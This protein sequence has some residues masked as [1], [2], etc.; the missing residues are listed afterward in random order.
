MRGTT[1]PHLIVRKH[2][3]CVLD[4][5]RLGEA[6]GQQV[7]PLL[8]TI[9]ESDPDSEVRRLAGLSLAGWNTH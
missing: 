8:R 7:I 6:V 5:R 1:S 9:A 3:V 2:A 4:E